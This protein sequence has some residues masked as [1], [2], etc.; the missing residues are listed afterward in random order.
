M[1]VKVRSLVFNSNNPYGTYLAGDTIEVYYDSSIDTSPGTNPFAGLTVY[2]N[3]VQIFSGPTIGFND[4]SYTEQNIDTLE[5]NNGYS[6]THSRVE[7]SFPY[8]LNLYWQGYGACEIIPS[9]GDIKFSPNITI[10]RASSLTANDGSITVLATSSYPIKYKIGSDF[11][12]Y[13]GTGSTSGTFGSLFAGSYRIYVRD[14]KNFANNIFVTVGVGSVY[15]VIYTI[16]YINL[17][18]HRTKIEILQRDYVSTSSDLICSDVPI[19]LEMRNESNLD[20]FQPLIS[21]QA[22]VGLISQT[23]KQFQSLFTNE[24]KK[25]Q[26]KYYKDTSGGTSYT[27]QWIG[28]IQPQIYQEEYLMP[29][30]NVSIQA[31]D[32]LVFL[33]D[34]VFLQDDGQKFFGSIRALTLIATIL[35]KTNLS[36]PIRCGCN[37]FADTMS[38]AAS[39]DPLD[40][41]YVDVDAYYI[42]TDQ[43]TFDFVLKCILKSL[44]ARLVQSGGYWNIFRP[45]EM[46][47]SF[48]YRDFDSDGNYVTNGSF[49]PIV[50]IGSSSSSNRLRWSEQDQN[51]E[52]RPGF[53]KLRINYHL[54]YKDNIIK[55][56]D[57]KLRP[58]W[59]TLTNSY[60]YQIDLFGFQ[61]I[62][63]FYAINITYELITPS[64]LDDAVLVLY[65]NN[66]LVKPLAYVQSV[67]YN[68]AMGVNNSI[69]IK[70]NVKCPSPVTYNLAIDGNGNTVLV[71][72]KLTPYYQKVRARIYY[73]N[74]YLQSDG[75][76]TTIPS[77]LI[78]Y[79]TQ[80]DQY[81]DLQLTANW[82]DASYITEKEFY[83][84]VYHS[85]DF[86]FDYED[87]TSLKRRL[88]N[89]N[90]ASSNNRGSFNA[91]SGMLP[92]TGGSGGGGA[93]QA[94]D[95]WT[96]NVAGT[97]Q[98][99][100]CAVGVRL[101]A[102]NNLPG[103]SLD[104]WLIGEIT[105]V[106]GTKTEVH[107]SSAY[108]GRGI[109]YYELENNTNAE[110]IP[111]IVRPNDY[112]SSTN[113][114]QW[115]LKK[116]AIET[117]DARAIYFYINKIQVQFLAN[118]QTPFDTI[119]RDIN[120]ESNNSLAV[121]DDI[122]H[123][124]LSNTVVNTTVSSLVSNVI[125]SQQ[126]P[127]NF[128]ISN[129]FPN[130]K[131]IFP[132]LVSF[133]ITQ[134]ILS[135][136]LIY[137]GYFRDSSGV[138]YDTWVRTGIF[139]SDSLHSIWLKTT[140]A[141]YNRSWKKITG[142]LY[143]D[144]FFFFV[145]VLKDTL[146]DNIVYLPA[147]FSYDD[148]ANQINGEFLELIDITEDAGSDGTTTSPYSSGFSSGFSGGFN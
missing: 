131:T 21:T 68:F 129:Q 11:D 91:S 107:D 7:T 125:T 51:L 89:S 90:V 67:S 24:P 38:K 127:L 32:G 18:G 121:E 26:V 84:R 30:Y 102:I 86:D 13:D 50:N 132:N 19:N 35:K 42:A 53:G 106:Q 144:V 93:I 116:S 124:S 39:D 133:P 119:V 54:G 60:D 76:W 137:T 14:S 117:N 8:I 77:D 33:S 110:N 41:A 118:G 145:N 141:Q 56:G 136:K 105:L 87:I 82:P 44:R 94:N 142:S 147:S 112:N 111:S 120:G 128:S 95:V 2:Q 10:I 65:A 71:P 88:T 48:N 80:F 1:S 81:I 130:N 55:N 62:S 73:G 64:N 104:N 108:L 45:E 34:L 40:Q 109:Y 74:K 57:F 29:P 122:Y 46:K 52:I 143:G 12:Y 69:L 114:N 47:G 75:S 98:G 63:P 79:V 3:S 58:T 138:G 126:S 61:V 4:S 96:I 113:P 97:I 135:G 78:F 25:Y 5:C 146:E 49:N 103:Q 66:P 9:V 16:S 139:E 23:D 22:T 43:P 83:I 27:L 70:I 134:N 85:T 6:V 31:T 17:A 37:V 123:G 148:K 115:I 100:Y 140:I 72:N 59:N 99:I 28:F 92:S 20:K 101:R 15:G 36:L